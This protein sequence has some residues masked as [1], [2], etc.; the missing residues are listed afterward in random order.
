MGT[1]LLRTTI[2]L[3]YLITCI[4]FLYL[5]TAETQHEVTDPLGKYTDD[6][7][8]HLTHMSEKWRNPSAYPAVA[9]TTKQSAWFYSLGCSNASA[10]APQ[11]YDGQDPYSI[12]VRKEYRLLS[13]EQHRGSQSGSAR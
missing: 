1:S 5:T 9:M 4:Q 12:N 8:N 7:R 13:G 11:I 10:V 6:D 2:L 3:L